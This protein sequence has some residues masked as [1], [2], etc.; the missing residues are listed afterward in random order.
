MSVSALQKF[1]M[2]RLWRHEIL[3][4]P[5]NPRV[6]GKKEQGRLK[7]KMK[8]VGLLQPLI[9]NRTTMRLLGG[10][11]RMTVM[12]SVEKFD[13]ITRANDYQIDVALVDL[14]EKEELEMLVFLNNP[15]AQ[16]E[17]DI[18]ILAEINLECGVEFEGMGFD[19]VD[20]DM[21]FDGDARFSELFEDDTEVSETKEKLSKVKAAREVAT[22]KLKKENSA[23]FY[24]VVVCK[25]QA[26]KDECLRRL[27][28]PPFEQFVS[29]EALL[30]SVEG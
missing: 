14:A 12:D 23:D 26:E 16:G 22:E 19:R 20:V 11:Q 5:Q 2:A 27:H 10:H 24:F 30:A 18:D 17:W 6:I 29:A 25:D 15:S 1:E 4:H 3:L 9:V 8:Q 13:A 7:G 21:L 28:I